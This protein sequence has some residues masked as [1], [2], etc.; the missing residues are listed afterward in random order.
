MA[1]T[2]N[3]MPKNKFIH[4]S[5]ESRFKASE[6]AMEVI[7]SPIETYITIIERLY[8]HAFRKPVLRSFEPFVK[9]LTVKGIIGNTQGVN[10]ANKPPPKPRTKIHQR[11][12]WSS[13]TA[14]SVLQVLFS[15]V[16]SKVS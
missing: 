16:L 7:K 9:K 6:P 10:K 15:K 11:L 2:R 12:L 14:P 8:N 5:V 13:G 1:K 3:K 4:G